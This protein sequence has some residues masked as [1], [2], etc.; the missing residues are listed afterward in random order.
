MEMLV[1]DDLLCGLVYNELTKSTTRVLGWVLTSFPLNSEQFH[2]YLSWE[3]HP[4]IV[5][6]LNFDN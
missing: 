4:H 6:E 1:P 5:K 3:L 2:K